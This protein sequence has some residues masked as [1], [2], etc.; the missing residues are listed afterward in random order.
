MSSSSSI[1]TRFK[2]AATILTSRFANS[3]FGGLKGSDQES[4]ITTASMYGSY[5]PLLA[6]HMHDGQGGDGH[7]QKINLGG[8][9]TDHASSVPAGL[10]H[11][12][13]RGELQHINLSDYSVYKNN[14]FRAN[15]EANTNVIPW[16]V[17]DGSGGHLYHL[18]LSEYTSTVVGTLD[19]DSVATVGNKTDQK[20]M[21][22]SDTETPQS[23][24]DIMADSTLSKHFK[25]LNTDSS[26]SST[27][28]SM[29][30]GTH[31]LEVS[32]K[33]ESYSGTDDNSFKIF[34]VHT[35]A[36]PPVGLELN[37]DQ[38]EIQ[39]ISKDMVS[40]SSSKTSGLGLKMETLDDSN[41]EISSNRASGFGPG[42]NLET[43]GGSPIHIGTQT[44]ST[45]SAS[46]TEEVRFTSE[47]FN[48]HPPL[49]S[50]GSPAISS[51]SHE[52]EF[53]NIYDKADIDST[54]KAV[55]TFDLGNKTSNS[56]NTD[57]ANSNAKIYIG[58]NA[59]QNTASITRE[60]ISIHVRDG[61]GPKLYLDDLTS[62]LA[63]SPT[64]PGIQ[65]GGQVD[66]TAVNN[67]T[68]LFSEILGSKES[69]SLVPAGNYG[70]KLE[71]KVHG[72]DSLIS[73]G[74]NSPYT[75]GSYASMVRVGIN[76]NGNMA[77]GKT[78]RSQSSAFHTAK[79]K[80][81]LIKKD[82]ERLIN[83][84]T[85]TMVES[86]GN[87]EDSIMSFSQTYSQ[88]SNSTPYN[89]KNLRYIEIEAPDFVNKVTSNTVVPDISFYTLTNHT[90]NGSQTFNSKTAAFLNFKHPV[91]DGSTDPT[92]SPYSMGKSAID[93]HPM[94]MTNISSPTYVSTAGVSIP[95]KPMNRIP[96]SSSEFGGLTDAGFYA[97]VN[98][99]MK[100]YVDEWDS[101][102]S[103]WKK[104]TYYVPLC[105]LTKS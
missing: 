103:V 81:A 71:F 16:R 5:D 83:V 55:F 3:M 99:W 43:W 48:F 80:P 105:S 51:Y 87:A 96:V 77:V 46:P 27:S 8:T 21:L 72:S 39:I 6:G 26:P 85:E 30:N 34:P 94:L 66:S 12:H 56:S 18:N 68:N 100:V 2:T 33:L 61:G 9:G 73:S 45:P 91:R 74:S 93:E 63:G 22:G 101:G 65:L 23:Q 32:S 15:L 102:S 44:Y 50:T 54:K 98:A 84:Q 13:V 14:S 59:K 86:D 28:F 37:S 4:D 57:P 75:T 47:Q 53:I 31:C 97:D 92:S 67:Q 76:Y 70:G 89:L 25:L 35:S 19:L 49:R 52:S 7:A 20:I 79:S 36:H 17:S 29:S 58:Q 64:K 88:E 90:D 104:V 62:G 69:P 78:E 60:D 1:L 38:G 24:L 42:I 11:P 40:L 10:G 41:I 95:N 82:Y